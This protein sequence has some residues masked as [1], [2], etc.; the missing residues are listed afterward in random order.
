MVGLPYVP[1]A[2]P[3]L[4]SHWPWVENSPAMPTVADLR[5]KEK[6]RSLVFSTQRKHF[7]KSVFHKKNCM[8]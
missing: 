6:E 4:Y 1:T 8:K 3:A 7:F 2:L 5:K